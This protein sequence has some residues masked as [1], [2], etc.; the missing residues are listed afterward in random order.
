MRVFETEDLIKK[1]TKDTSKDVR[2]TAEF[3]LKRFS[4][5]KNETE[6]KPRDIL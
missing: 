4:R 3:I 1:A 2:E 5:M 6:Y